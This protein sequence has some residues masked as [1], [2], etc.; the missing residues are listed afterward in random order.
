MLHPS[1]LGIISALLLLL[2]VEFFTFPDL[3]TVTNPGACSMSSSG[4]LP[5]LAEDP[6]LFSFCSSLLLFFVLLLRLF[7]VV[8]EADTE[9]EVLS[10]STAASS[11]RLWCFWRSTRTFSIK[12]LSHGSLISSDTMVGAHGSTT[13]LNLALMLSC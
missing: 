6:L 8:L 2:V 7:P 13:L 3:E 4:V 5:V 11:I 1:K 9:L 10:S 12:S